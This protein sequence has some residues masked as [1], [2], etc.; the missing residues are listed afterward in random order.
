[1]KLPPTVLNTD[2]NGLVCYVRNWMFCQARNSTD[3]IITE[4]NAYLKN[5]DKTVTRTHQALLVLQS[6]L[7]Q[8]ANNYVPSQIS[9]LGNGL[10]PRDDP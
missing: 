1:M 10:F 5:L 9:S 2:L 8:G 4:N 6:T 7:S 3:L